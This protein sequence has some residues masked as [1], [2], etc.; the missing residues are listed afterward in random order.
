M[1]H[2]AVLTKP[3][4]DVKGGWVTRVGGRGSAGAPRNGLGWW[5][6]GSGQGLLTQRPR[7]VPQWGRE[8]KKSVMI[9]EVSRRGGGGDREA[10]LGE[11]GWG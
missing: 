5:V 4:T 8:K 11:R 10:T 2:A 7:S 3:N 6:G 1:G 9:G